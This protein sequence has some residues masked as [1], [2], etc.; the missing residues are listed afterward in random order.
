MKF[1]SDVELTS[2]LPFMQTP[3]TDSTQLQQCY[4]FS[5]YYS[6][7]TRWSY[8]SGNPDVIVL[9]VDKL[10]CWELSFAP[11]LVAL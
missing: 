10:Q 7:T 11:V 3:R 8:S 5:N 1:Y 9:S 6:T 4:R 2:P